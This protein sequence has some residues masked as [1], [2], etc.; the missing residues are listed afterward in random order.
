MINKYISVKH[1]AM[2][3]A[4]VM[5]MMTALG[6]FSSSYATLYKPP[7][8]VQTDSIISS[9]NF[10]DEYYKVTTPLNETGVI[11]VEGKTKVNTKRF[12]IRLLPHGSTSA[13]ITVFV[14]PDRNGEF[15][16]KISTKKGNAKKGTEKL[17]TQIN[18]LIDSS[19]PKSSVLQ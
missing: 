8:P 2:I 14:V 11:Y 6:S 19:V 18:G 17:P 9:N 15:S 13:K 1:T 12:C 3:I 10:T 7:E 4:L 5:L 16:I